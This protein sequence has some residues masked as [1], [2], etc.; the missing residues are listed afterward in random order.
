M[1]IGME[2]ITVGDF[3][4]SNKDKKTIVSYRIPPSNNPI[5]FCIEIS[6]VKNNKTIGI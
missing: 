5:D 1:L 3:A 6:N 4:I 2:I